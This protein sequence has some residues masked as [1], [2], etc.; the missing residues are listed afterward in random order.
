M[1]GSGGRP[2]YVT[3]SETIAL[4]KQHGIRLRKGLGQHFLVDNNV[5]LNILDAAKVAPGET[6]LEVGPGIGSLTRGLADRAARVV[7]VEV[8][9]RMVECFRDNVGAGNV[10]LLR[11]D[12]MRLTADDVAAAGAS[13]TKLVANLPYNIAVPLLLDLLERFPDLSSAVVMVQREVADRLTAGVG[14]KSYG[15]VTVKLA[16]Y[17]SVRR[18]FTVPPTVFVPPPRVESAVVELRRA[19][20]DP[21]D[22]EEVFKIVDAAFSQR[23]KTLA[24]ALSAGSEGLDR[25]RIGKA[26]E[27]LR[28]GANARAQELSVADF[29]RLAEALARL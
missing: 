20:A 28:I 12:A 11:M 7:A 15:G 22:R 18:L 23:R 29:V 2:V 6:V 1:G 24:N 26:M 25:E 19:R 10:V 9:P 14:G 13:P 3:P 4:L 16:Y 17:G 27:L 21:G 5:L 8:D